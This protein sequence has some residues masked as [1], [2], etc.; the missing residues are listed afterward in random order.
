[1][2]RNSRLNRPHYLH[3]IIVTLEFFSSFSALDWAVNISIKT[4]LVNKSC[5]KEAHVLQ[6]PSLLSYKNNHFEVHISL[7]I[8]VFLLQTTSYEFCQGEVTLPSHPS[9]ALPPPHTFI[10]ESYRK[11]FKEPQHPSNSGTYIL[12][13]TVLLNSSVNE[14]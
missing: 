2:K 12:D 10:L 3:K 7:F 6:S 13:H 8:G 14:K 4:H 11:G 9:D 1:M 5:F